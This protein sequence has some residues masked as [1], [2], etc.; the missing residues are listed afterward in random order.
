MTI[1]E[2]PQPAA[3]EDYYTDPH[4]GM[5]GSDRITEACGACAGTGLYTAPTWI[6]D[7]TGRPY[8]FRCHGTGTHSR[9]VSSARATA[10]AHAK[11]RA[12]HVDQ[13]RSIT[14]R[15]AEFEV[16]HPGLRDR[17]TEAHIEL[18][19]GN[20]L[21][22]RI[23]WL[24]ESL[25]DTTGVLDD[26]ELL[27]AHAAL[28]QHAQELAAR[29][30]VPTG[31]VT[32]QGEIVSTRTDDTRFGTVVKILLQ[33]DGWRLWGTKPA[34][35]SSAARGDIVEFTATISASDDDESFGFFARPTKAHVIAASIR[36]SA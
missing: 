31:R 22:A 15:R 16:A 36:R 25:E 8:C 5:K 11:A 4:P 2:I 26:Q 14:A 7:S 23:G 21:R 6:T 35:I 27:D 24:L 10:R 13:V 17:L 18:R 9:L 3:W 28:E 29:R 30:P 20:P 1:T 33:G 19:D 12:E 32:V 34:A